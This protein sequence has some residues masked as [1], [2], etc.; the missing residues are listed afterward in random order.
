MKQ[1]FD[2]AAFEKFL[3]DR[4]KVD[5]RTGQLGEKVKLTR[6]GGYSP[7]GPVSV[8]SSF[9]IISGESIVVQTNIHFSKRYLKYL[10]KKFL[11]RNQM[12]EWL[13]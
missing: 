7:M 6:D 11:K 13:R 12:R 10:T 5:G 9:I 8:T 2:G 3:Y 1:I 4:I